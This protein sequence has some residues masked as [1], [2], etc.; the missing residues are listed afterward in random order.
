MFGF[1]SRRAKRITE[2]I[3]RYITL[4]LEMNFLNSSYPG[5]AA[6]RKFAYREE[7]AKKVLKEIEDEL[8]FF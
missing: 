1:R 4:R 3:D 7:E 5:S 8:R 6:Q 2:N